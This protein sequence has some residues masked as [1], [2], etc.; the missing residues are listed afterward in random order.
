MLGL[1]FLFWVYV[2]G[3]SVVT[4]LIMSI[5]TVW[6]WRAL[7]RKIQCVCI[8]TFFSLPLTK[9]TILE[10]VFMALMALWMLYAHL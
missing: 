10:N 7:G 3:A 8:G 9:V 1:L 6:V 4:A 2:L 5:G